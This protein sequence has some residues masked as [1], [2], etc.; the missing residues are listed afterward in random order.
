MQRV[1][2]SLN[3]CAA[4]F[5]KKNQEQVTMKTVPV[6]SPCLA[7][8]EGKEVTYCWKKWNEITLKLRI[9]NKLANDVL[10]AIKCNFFFKDF[11][12]W[13]V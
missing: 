12:Y 9:K 8:R 13:N 3:G 2:S 4:P 6:S 7:G 10:K 11:N 1:E 5:E